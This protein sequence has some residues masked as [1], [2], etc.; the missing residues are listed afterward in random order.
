MQRLER[1]VALDV[2]TGACS[3]TTYAYHRW[4]SRSAFTW[5]LYQQQ[6]LISLLPL[7]STRPHPHRVAMPIE[8]GLADC[9]SPWYRYRGNNWSQ[10]VGTIKRQFREVKE[11]HAPCV[12]FP[13]SRRRFRATC[14]RRNTLIDLGGAV[15]LLRTGTGSRSSV[16]HMLI[17]VERQPPP[18]HQCLQPLLY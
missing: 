5:S 10:I 4:M 16:D 18:K 15:I 17:M 9:D 11:P 6:T 2:G 13:Y 7:L 8:K 12:R 3:G 1:Y 14:E